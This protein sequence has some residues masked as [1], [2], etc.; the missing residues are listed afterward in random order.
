MAINV[1]TVYK[2]VLLILNQQQR[3]YMTPD[4]FNKVG[5]QVQ[6]NMFENYASDLNQQ[7]RVAQNDTEYAN[8]VKNIDEKIDIFKKIGSANYNTS[9]SYFTLPYADSSP[10]FVENEANNG[11]NSYTIAGFTSNNNSNFD[12]KWRVTA[13]GTEVYNYTFTTSGT[14]TQFVFTNSPAGAMV[15]QA[16][17]M[18]FY[19]IGTVIYNDT[20]EVQMIDRNEWYLIKKAP[21]VAPTTSQPVCLY[22]DQKIYIYPTSIVNSVQ[23]SYIKKPSNP[24][25]G[26]VSGALGQYNYYEPSSTQFE[27]HPSEQTEL[28]LKIL[29]YA[30]VIIE[31][32]NLV[33]IAA[34]KVQGDDLNEKS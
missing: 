5:A 28:I 10:Y 6:L 17:S 14:G 22:E 12:T 2:T 31:D 33:Q 3:G 9:G 4:E 7:Y 8:R 30:G 15:F 34:Q 25:W 27:L 13:G 18:D 11:S 32:P 24:V 1:N 26:Y 19:R 29:M 21:L 23:V 16:Y 20:T